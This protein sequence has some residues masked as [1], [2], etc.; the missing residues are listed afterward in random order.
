MSC[1]LTPDAQW[2]S[3]A[4]VSLSSAVPDLSQ[5]RQPDGRQWKCCKWRHL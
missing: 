5:V 3:S 1:D 4:R 2:S